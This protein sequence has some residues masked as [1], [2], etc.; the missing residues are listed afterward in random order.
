MGIDIGVGIIV[1]VIVGVGVD[2]A[3]HVV[4]SIYACAGVICTPLSL[5][6]QGNNGMK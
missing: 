2:L 5:S 4:V 1:H 3:V 6:L